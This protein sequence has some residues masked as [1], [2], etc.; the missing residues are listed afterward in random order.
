MVRG[1]HPKQRERVLDILGIIATATRPLKWREVQGALA[2]DLEKQEIN[3]LKR[4]ISKMPKEICSSLVEERAN[5]NVELVHATAREYLFTLPEINRVGQDIKLSKLCLTLLADSGFDSINCGS[6][7]ALE[8]R[9]RSGHYA[10]LDYAVSSWWHHTNRCIQRGEDK[11]ALKS[12][13]YTLDAFLDVHYQATPGGKRMNNRLRSDLKEKMGSWESC[14][15]LN[16]AI[17]AT[18]YQVRSNGPNS[19]QNEALD[20]PQMLQRVRSVMELV[21]RAPR[22]PEDRTGRTLDLSTLYG[23]CLFKCSRMGCF[24]FSE[25]FDNYDRRQAHI[26]KHEKPFQCTYPACPHAD[27]G[28][29]NKSQL[30]THLKTQHGQHTWDDEEFPPRRKLMVAD[31]DDQDADIQEKF[32]PS[33]FICDICGQNFTRSVNL[34]GHKNSHKGEK[35]HKCSFCGLAFARSNDCRRHENLH[36]EKRKHVCTGKLGEQMYG[37]ETW[38]CNKEF[39]RGHKLVAH[40]VYEDESSGVPACIQPLIQQVHDPNLGGANGKYVCQGKLKS[41]RETIEWGCKTE[42]NTVKQLKKHWKHYKGRTCLKE[43]LKGREEPPASELELEEETQDGTAAADPGTAGNE[44]SQL[45]DPNLQLPPMTQPTTYGT[46]PSFDQVF[47]NI[48]THDFNFGND[49]SALE[50]FDFDSFLPTDGYD[51]WTDQF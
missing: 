8:D 47:G 49:A 12:L 35:P 43:I 38:G 21:A 30:S 15:R 26:D 32:H 23:T 48:G 14:D 25:G 13:R 17:T 40:Y 11:S 6:D 41:A 33:K 19:D 37:G 22:I 36:S 28:F 29:A 39:R 2:I 44:T 31:D 3:F 45:V 5:G 1:P 4:R 10:F 18:R 7:Q 20:V 24:Y 42:F 27:I 50:G 16:H 9:L 51:Q 46:L 34:D